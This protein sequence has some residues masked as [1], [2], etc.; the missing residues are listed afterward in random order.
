MLLGNC[1]GIRC[2]V[3]KNQGDQG[4]RCPYVCDNFMRFFKKFARGRLL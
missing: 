4:N 1:E 2:L 3:R